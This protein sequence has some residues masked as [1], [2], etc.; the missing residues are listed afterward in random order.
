MSR[1][2]TITPRNRVEYNET[3]PC[4]LDAYDAP[5]SAFIS[6][7]SFD[8]PVSKAVFLSCAQSMAFSKTA[9]LNQTSNLENISADTTSKM[10]RANDAHAHTPTNAVAFNSLVAQTQHA[11]IRIPI[12]FF[13]T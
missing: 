10:K 9:P 6:V 12:S 11:K 4:T 2:L 8:S 3:T 5:N 13:S 1:I 7:I